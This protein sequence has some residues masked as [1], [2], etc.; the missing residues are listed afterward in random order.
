VWDYENKNTAVLLPDLSRVTLTYNGEQRRVT[1]ETDAATQKFVYDGEN[2]LHVTDE[3]DLTQAVYTLDPRQYGLLVSQRQNDGGWQTLYHHFDA[4]GSTDALTDASEVV[5]DTYTYYAFGELKTSTGT[6]ANPCTW[7]AEV[8]YWKDTDLD[9][10]HLGA[11]EYE[12]EQ[13]RFISKD[14]L[15]VEPDP[16]VYRYLENAPVNRSDPSGME[17]QPPARPDPKK[18]AD[19][20][21]EIFVGDKRPPKWQRRNYVRGEAISGVDLLAL[22]QVQRFGF[23]DKE[24]SFI[25]YYTPKTGEVT[26]SGYR[27]SRSLDRILF[28]VQQERF[29]TPTNS[30]GWDAFFREFE[31][32]DFATANVSSYADATKTEAS[33]GS[34]RDGVALILP[35]VGALGVHIVKEAAIQY[36]AAPAGGKLCQEA[37]ENQPL[38]GASKPAVNGCGVRDRLCVY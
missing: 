2:L 35:T 28:T 22:I 32:V 31:E 36:I 23:K 37:R 30:E 7:V 6:T 38:G 16:N 3:S 10:F 27:N 33:G 24:I 29:D 4:L 14:P 34:L 12:P 17:F 5:T 18:I 25:G 8:G 19:L 21:K 20:E 11:R 15:G 13:A 1:K 9:R 26:R